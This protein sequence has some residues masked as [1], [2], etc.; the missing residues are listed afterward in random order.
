VSPGNA[1]NAAPR[2]AQR[3]RMHPALGGAPLELHYD[4]LSQTGALIMADGECCDM[5]ACIAL[6]AA[7]DPGVGVI[8]T[9]SRA[10]QGCRVPAPRAGMGGGKPPQALGGPARLGRLPVHLN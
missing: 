8:V 9:F 10:R 1:G 5:Q 6:F 3:L 7:I 2:A 4:F